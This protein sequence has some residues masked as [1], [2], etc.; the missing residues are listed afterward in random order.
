M[1]KITIVSDDSKNSGLMH[2]FDLAE[3]NRNG[4]EDT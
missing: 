1:N 4:K 2:F 3:S